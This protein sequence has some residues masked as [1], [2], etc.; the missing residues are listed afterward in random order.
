VP[1]QPGRF[2]RLAIYLQEISKTMKNILLPLSMALLL[3]LSA[4]LQSQPATSPENQDPDPVAIS[5]QEA[6][7]LDDS[8]APAAS[9][10]AAAAP[11]EIK[12]MPRL[13][14]NVEGLTPEAG[15]VEVSL[16]NSTETFM[17]KPFMQD[18]GVP[19]AEGKLQVMF[20]NV[21]EGEYGLVVVHDEN[22][23]GL[24]DSGFLGFGAEP[25]A[26][27]NDAR[28]WLGRPA[29]EAVSF[30]VQADLEVT[31]RMD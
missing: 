21:F 7:E 14:V 2:A 8:P 26:Y 24:Y 31:I 3:M 28:P 18:S 9:I 6:P 22:D 4:P 20:L 30:E 19:D 17:I 10:K 5:A 27:S 13:T 16:F 1:G 12:R 23:N 25:V 29:F 11:I 15:K